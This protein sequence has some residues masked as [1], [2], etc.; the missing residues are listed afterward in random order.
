MDAFRGSRL[1]CCFKLQG[2]QVA[3]YVS[4]ERLIEESKEEYYRVLKLCS[5]GWHKG[6][7]QIV[8]WWNYFLSMLRSGYK[9]FERQV[10]SVEAR[11]AKSDLVRQIVLAQMAPFTLADMAAQLP[12]ASS[13]LIKKVLAEMKRDGRVRLAGRGRGAHWE[14]AGGRRDRAWPAPSDEDKRA[15]P[16]RK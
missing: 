4:L 14:I 13:Q 9:E 1:H 12:V 5:V 11:P 15:K 6:K 16:P 7:N 8:P 2:F 10:A 3:R